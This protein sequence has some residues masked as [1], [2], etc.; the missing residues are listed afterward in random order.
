MIQRKS[1]LSEIREA[2]S[3]FP[4]VGIIGPRQ[5]GKTT[6]AKEIIKEYDGIY[7]DLERD[8]DI[9]RLTE[10][11]IFLERNSN[12]LIVL[13]EIKRMPEIFPLLRALIDDDNRCARFLILGSAAPALIRES[14]ES[15]AGRIKYIELQPFSLF[16]T[17]PSKLD[18]LWLKGGFPRAYISANKESW[19]WREAFF[20]SYIEQDLPEFGLDVDRRVLRNFF[21]MMALLNG[22]ALNASNL[23][24][25][26]GKTSPTIH[27]YVNYA[28]QTYFI[29]LLEP[30]LP[31]LRKRLIKSPKL[32]FKDSGILHSLLNIRT[33]DDLMGHPEL[34]FSWESFAIQQILRTSNKY[35]AF[36]YRTSNGAEIDLILAEGSKVQYAIDFKFSKSPKI[37]RSL[38]EALN[39]VNAKN[40]LIIIP[41]G[42]S[43]P[44]RK[45]VEVI[46]LENFLLEISN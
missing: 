23:A 9:T 11:E 38:T 31:N 46:S 37:S 22:Q 8:S 15:L 19:D 18:E 6:I 27:K 44:L 10:P 12:K 2:L 29:H 4:A 41:F 42:D 1:Y 24:R 45:N 5:V 35:Q 40:N 21:R 25:S 34:G 30:Y 28:E 17:S 14:S 33:M 7:L 39:D 26:L 3:N 43:F 32:Y 36:Y 16:E 20:K 13:D